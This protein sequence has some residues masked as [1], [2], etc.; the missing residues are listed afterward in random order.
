[1]PDV[2]VCLV[3]A[4][5]VLLRTGYRPRQKTLGRSIGSIII[6][7]NATDRELPIW[8]LFTSPTRRKAI[9]LVAVS[10]CFSSFNPS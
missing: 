6:I 9:A 3:R 7:C 1:V 10:V 2:P 5:L 4:L 8:R